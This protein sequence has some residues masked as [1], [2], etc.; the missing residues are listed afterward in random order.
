MPGHAY[1][2]IHGHTW[3]RYL[4]ELPGWAEC[5]KWL[6]PTQVDRRSGKGE[7]WDN[8]WSTMGGIDVSKLCHA[9]FAE[10]LPLLK[11]LSQEQIVRAEAGRLK[12]LAE[13]NPV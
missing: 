1:R 8:P 9:C 3:H 11:L 10:E 4:G 13:Q 12:W 5:G 2:L 7:K 6:S